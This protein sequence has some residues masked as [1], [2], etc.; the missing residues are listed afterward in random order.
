NLLSNASKYSEPAARIAV[1]CR[2]TSG[3]RATIVVRDEGIG[4]PKEK[5]DSVFDL[6][7]QVDQSLA[8]SLG[9]LGIGL[10]I[11]RRL[12]ELH[13]GTIRAE[14]P[15]PGRGSSFVLELPLMAVEVGTTIAD[16][17]LDM[18][19]AADMGP[20]LTILLVEDNRDAR[21]TLRAWLEEVGHEVT[22][23]ADGFE[24]L[25]LARRIRP[26]VAL[27]D[28]GLPGIDGY[29]VARTMRETDGC[30]DA[31]L[32]AITGYGR[33]EDSARAREAGF[34][35]HLVKPVQP[36][37]L[38]RVLRAARSHGESATPAVP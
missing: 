30:R 27:I 34:D 33:P 35:V 32:I 3:D 26:Q 16:P 20:P 10:T 12:V 13:G 1:E 24:A 11:A 9:G 29:Q 14:S 4:I 2:R 17:G 8:R 38:S 37:G 22:S 6:F 7:F 5:L 21:E 25:Q 23:A 31:F 28:N 15:G 18:S 19:E 36:E